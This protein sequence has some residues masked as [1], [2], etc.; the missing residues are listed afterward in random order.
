[1]N[2][3][4]KLFL[5]EMDI[6]RERDNSNKRLEMQKRVFAQRAEELRRLLEKYLADKEAIMNKY[7]SQLESATGDID[8][9]S[10]L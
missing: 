8:S 9:I 1:M 7:A 2:N 3:Q 5:E 4:F 10:E 6:Q